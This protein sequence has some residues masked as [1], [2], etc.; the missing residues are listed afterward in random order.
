M[1]QV[2]GEREIVVSVGDRGV[3]PDEGDRPD[4]ANAA[5]ERHHHG[6][7]DTQPAQQAEVVVVHRHADP[8]T[9]TRPAEAV[10]EA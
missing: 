8:I 9:A 7:A 10:I 2:L 1:S 5:D 3:T 4:A 6:A